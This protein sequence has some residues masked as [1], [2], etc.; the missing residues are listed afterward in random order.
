MDVSS[1]LL[2]IGAALELAAVDLL[3]GGDNAILIALASRTLSPALRPRALVYAVG[4]AIVLRFLLAG[5]VGVLM[6]IPFI[7]LGGAVVL[8][9]IAI[10]LLAHAH[11]SEGE[12]AESGGA[13]IYDDRFWRAVVAIIGADAVMSLD[14]VLALASI[15]QGNLPLLA[16]GIALGIPALVFGSFLVAKVLDRWPVLIYAGA[17]LLGWVAA[18]MAMTDAIWNVFATPR[19]P[20]LA[21][22]IPMLCAAFVL[23]WGRFGPR[24]NAPPPTPPG[25][26]PP[27][28][29]KAIDYLTTAERRERRILIGAAALIIAVGAVLLIVIERR[30]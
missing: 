30:A 9:A 7:K 10:E 20:L 27:K 18:E 16:L 23:V 14:N 12:H 11:A 26:I 5:A 22:A 4:G 24:R 8:I 17:A 2:F 13:R 21:Y 25:V 29:K 1:P 28:A 3:L 19:E 15:A 6:T